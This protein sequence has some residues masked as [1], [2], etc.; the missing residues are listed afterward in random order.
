MPTLD[1]YTLIEKLANNINELSNSIMIQQNSLNT[2]ITTFH[3]EMSTFKVTMQK[4]VDSSNRQQVESVEHVIASESEPQTAIPER[5]QVQQSMNRFISQTPA[6]IP[7]ALNTSITYAQWFVNPLHGSTMQQLYYEWFVYK[8]HT[9]NIP[10]NTEAARRMSQFANAIYYAKLFLP[11][12]TTISVVPTDS[13]QYNMWAQQISRQSYDSQVQ[14]V[15]YLRITS[16]SLTINVLIKKFRDIPVSDLPN[17]SPVNDYATSDR[18]KVTRSQL[19]AAEENRL[20]QRN[21]KRNR[22][23]S[24]EL[25]IDATTNNQHG[26]NLN[27]LSTSSNNNEE[28]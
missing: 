24:N 16:S 18:W 15:Q 7:N 17:P 12:N 26:H 19:V 23:S 11:T 10:P 14:M 3:R 8:L 20:R 9:M 1:V 22:E 2:L 5:R 27:E 13:Q 21:L 4:L 28:L 25:S 6:T